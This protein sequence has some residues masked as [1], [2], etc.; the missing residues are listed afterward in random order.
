M[1]PYQLTALSRCVC[2]ALVYENKGAIVMLKRMFCAVVVTVLAMNGMA[3]GAVVGDVFTED[4][5]GM[6]VGAFPTPNGTL[7]DGSAAPYWVHDNWG[8][9]TEPLVMEATWANSTKFFGVDAFAAGKS[10]G[11]NTGWIIAAGAD[12]HPEII[13]LEFDMMVRMDFAINRGPRVYLTDSDGGW[14]TAGIN[15]R[16]PGSDEPGV[17]IWDPSGSND[18]YVAPALEQEWQHYE[19]IVN[20]NTSTISVSVDGSTPV[21]VTYTPSDGVNRATPDS[22]Y[23][24]GLGSKYVRR[25]FLDNFRLEVLPEPASLALLGM[26]GLLMLARRRSQ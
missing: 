8:Y 23:I 4:F 11:A 20:T 2:V 5:E 21:T 16:N 7:D 14:H 3:M 1:L 24:Y 26:G 9:T 18:V 13:K 17:T 25:Y 22:V 12:A 6:T 10:W 19:L 15:W